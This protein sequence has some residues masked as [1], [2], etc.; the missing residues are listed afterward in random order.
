[1]G[2]YLV[3]A[4]ERDPAGLNIAHEL[5]D[6]LEMKPVDNDQRTQIF[7]QE[8]CNLAIVK[9]ELIYLEDLNDF[10]L[11]D[12]YIFLSRHKAKNGIRCLTSHFTGNLSESNDYGG[13][14]LEIAYASPCL[15][16]SY[17]CHL[18]E[19]KDHVPTYQIVL[20]PVHHGP[21]SLHRPTL[22]VEIGP[23]E[24]EWNDLDA[25]KTVA[26]CVKHLVTSKPQLCEK[27]GIGF[28]GTHYSTKFTD[29][30][31]NSDIALGPV[32]PKYHLPDM[33][34]QMVKQMVAKSIEPVQY[35]IVDWKGLG[36]EKGKI[37]KLVLEAGLE[38]LRI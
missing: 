35:A 3:V 1:M 23:S 31:I 34:G 24:A 18:W 25:C 15:L 17:M 14:P 29:L 19:M 21:T 4:S 20:E 16:K 12:A 10:P 5:L 28:G 6:L 22:F 2:N 30:I 27:V 7:S 13:K 33:N 11:P 36:T 38:L 32:A 9:D 37:V 26:L 8:D